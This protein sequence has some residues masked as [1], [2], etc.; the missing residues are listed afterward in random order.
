MLYKQI[1]TNDLVN[2]IYLNRL[3]TQDDP[4]IRTYIYIYIIYI[5]TRIQIVTKDVV[6]EIY[7]D[8]V[9]TQDVPTIHEKLVETMIEVPVDKVSRHVCICVCARL[10]VCASVCLCGL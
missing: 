2:K 6:K 3:E 9:V 5:H 4:T 1:V 8:R 7:L 10:C